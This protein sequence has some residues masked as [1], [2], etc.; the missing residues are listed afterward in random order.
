MPSLIVVSGPNQGDYYPLEAETT[1]V[2]RDA[3]CPIQ[4]VDEMISRVHLQIRY[5][6][7]HKTYHAQDMDSANGVMINGNALSSETELA[8]G[9]VMELGGTK[10]VYFTREFPNRDDAWDFYKLSGERG[11]GTLIQPPK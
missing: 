5:A 6:K 4:I 9:D 8:N 7:D 3:K 1:V 10:I 2:G 11:K